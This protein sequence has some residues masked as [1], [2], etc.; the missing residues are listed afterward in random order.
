[1]IHFVY[2]YGDKFESQPYGGGMASRI[3]QTGQPLLINRNIGTRSAELNISRVGI[4][5]KSY[6]GVPIPVGNEIIGVISVQSTEREDRF[7]ETDLRLL[8]TIAA[9]VGV[10]VH[11]AQ[12]FEEARQ[13]RLL[14]EGADA[15]KSS[16]LSTVSHELR[17]PLTSVLGFAKIIKKRLDEKLFPLIPRDDPRVVKSMQQV[18]ENLNV[19]VTEGERLTKLID[20]V[21]DLAKIESGKLEWKMEVLSVPEIIDRAT[22]ATS[23]LFEAKSLKLN[24]DIEENLPK[25]TGDRDRLIQVAINL[26]SNA[27]KFTDQGSV[28]FKARREDGEVIIS[29]IDTGTRELHPMTSRRSSRSSNR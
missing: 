29:V 22:A 1:M 4:P 28:S 6:L 26:I 13:A 14:A 9:N 25:I 16:F 3:L 2:G 10:A 23:S 17:T 12:L 8:T 7:G 27:V 5:S 19:V 18:D 24:V 15:A 11:N 20:E 21:L